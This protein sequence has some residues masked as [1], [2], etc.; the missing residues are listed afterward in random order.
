LIY[1]LIVF[2]FSFLLEFRKSGECGKEIDASKGFKFNKGSAYC[3][4]IC[5]ANAN[6]KAAGAH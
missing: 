5:S 4:I 3:S 6:K 1:F 2:F